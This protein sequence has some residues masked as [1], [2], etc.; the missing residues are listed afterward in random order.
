MSSHGRR[1]HEQSA[2]T[3][4][5]RS[6][7]VSFT[8]HLDAQIEA[9]ALRN[10]T[11]ERRREALENLRRLAVQLEAAS[12]LDRRADRSNP[13]LAAVL[14]ERADE[15][16][17]IAEVVRAHLDAEGLSSDCRRLLPRRSRP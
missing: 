10:R 2:E 12:A 13:T 9:I 17:R 15:R 6:T 16:R 8:R 4:T 3:P 5:V 1:L 7:A 11:V 14:R